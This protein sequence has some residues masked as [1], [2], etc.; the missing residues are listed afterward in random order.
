[1]ATKPSSKKSTSKE[2]GAAKPAPL[3]LYRVWRNTAGDESATRLLLSPRRR[4]M[5]RPKL[6][7]MSNLQTPDRVLGHRLFH[8]V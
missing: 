3:R 1:M 5:R 4:R 7:H 8:K 6:K 2:T